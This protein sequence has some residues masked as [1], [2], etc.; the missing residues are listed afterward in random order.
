MVVGIGIEC[1]RRRGR[2]RAR[3]NS[4]FDKSNFESGAAGR[5]PR[6]RERVRR[7]L[8]FGECAAAVAVQIALACLTPALPQPHYCRLC[9]QHA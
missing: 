5:A 2:N 9:S 3:F 1:E 8:N 4:Y 7:M 6:L